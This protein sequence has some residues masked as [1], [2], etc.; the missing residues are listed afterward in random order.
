MISSCTVFVLHSQLHYVSS[1]SS[2][3]FV[4]DFCLFGEMSA[5]VAYSLRY[6][7]LFIAALTITPTLLFK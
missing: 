5:V 4:Y 6:L 7:P 2:F 3:Y 1:A